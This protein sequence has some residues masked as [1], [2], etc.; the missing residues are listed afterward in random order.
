MVKWY[1]LPK[2]QKCPISKCYSG[3]DIWF[4]SILKVVLRSL[5]YNA[6]KEIHFLSKIQTL[7]ILIFW[8]FCSNSQNS[9]WYKIFQFSTLC[10][11]I[12]FVFS[13]LSHCSGYY[14][15]QKVQKI[16][17]CKVWILLKKWIFS[18]ALYSRDLKT[19]FR[20]ELNQI[21]VSE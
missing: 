3:T 21:L 2:T 12:F 19:T 7:Q 15:L 8:T 9:V 11:S 1:F 4:Y 17:I 14:L 10:D 20:I 16:W 18:L 5:E 6:N 13:T